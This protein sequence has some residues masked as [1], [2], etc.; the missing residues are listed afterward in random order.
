[1]NALAIDLQHILA[2][3]RGLWERLRGQSLFITGGTGFFGRWLLESLCHANDS[4]GLKAR[5]MVLTRDPKRFEAKVPWLACHPTIRLHAGDCKSFGFPAGEFQ[6]IIHAAA[7]TDPLAEPLRPAALFEANVQATQRVLGLARVCGARRLLL[8]SSG[9]VYGPQP[10]TLAHIPEDYSGGPVP[11]DL[12]TAYGQSK[13]VSEFLSLAQAQETGL[14]VTIAR[15]FAFVG[16]YLPMDLN[17]A[18]GNFTRDA[19]RGGPIRVAGDGTPRRSYLYAADLAIWLWTILLLGRPGRPYNVG[20]DEDLSIAELAHTVAEVVNPAA[21]TL[22]ARQPDPARPLQR[23]VPSV[24]RARKELGLQ[25]LIPLSQ[26]I[27]RMA[28]W[29]QQFN[30]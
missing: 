18:V 12:T 8:T 2:H 28:D 26:G 19:L 9:A 20:S 17:F 21:Q 4:L 6:Y 16:P 24:D 10:S 11:D 29:H 25:P 15:G 23:Y 1:M 7:E 30:Q 5:V 13:R 3:T 27:R 14:E 22:F